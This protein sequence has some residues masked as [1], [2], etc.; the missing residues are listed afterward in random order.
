PRARVILERWGGSEPLNA[1]VRLVE[2]S[3][4][5]K[6]SALGV[7]EQRVHV[8][9]DFTDPVER[10]ATLGD[11]FRVEA[12]IV[13]W[14]H[15]DTLRTAAGALF[16]RGGAWQA[17]AIEG[18]RAHLRTVTVGRS[19]GILTEVRHGLDAGEQVVVYP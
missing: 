2:P 15:P 3:A 8:I 1:R 11:N 10:R 17:Y 14:E 7:E 6:I 19:D 18:G 9:A 12:R 13:V 5:T 4:F 16:Q